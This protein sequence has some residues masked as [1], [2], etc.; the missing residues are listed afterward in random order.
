MIPNL[1]T[2][3]NKKWAGRARRREQQE[4]EEIRVRPDRE[5]RQ[6]AAWEAHKLYESLYES[7]CESYKA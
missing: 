2:K 5:A 7:L 6:R 1:L 3:W 4:Q